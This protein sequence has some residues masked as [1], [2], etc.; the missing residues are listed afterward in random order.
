[1]DICESQ[2]IS[3]IDEN[4]QELLVI[5]LDLNLTSLARACGEQIIKNMVN[6]DL[7]DYNE[8]FPEIGCEYLG[9]KREKILKEVYGLLR[10]DILQKKIDLEYQ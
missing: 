5:A 8:I 3:S 1:M 2:L 7:E 4:C 6:Q 9:V 10:F